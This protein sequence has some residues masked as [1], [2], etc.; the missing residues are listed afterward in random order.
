MEEW[1]RSFYVIQIFY[2]LH[3]DWFL[4]NFENNQGKLK[5]KIS[6]IMLFEASVVFFYFVN[7]FRILGKKSDSIRCTLKYCLSTFDNT[8]CFLSFKLWKMIQQLVNTTI[9]KIFMPNFCEG[10]AQFLS[11][12]GFKNMF[13]IQVIQK[14]IYYFFLKMISF[15]WVS[16]VRNIN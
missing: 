16:F 7:C 14:M 6:S 5:I 2:I 13:R 9:F 10:I 12:K 8:S 11:T 15:K 3:S 1:S 4:H